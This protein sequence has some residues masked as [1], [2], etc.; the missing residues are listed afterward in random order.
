MTIEYRRVAK[1]RKKKIRITIGIAIAVLLALLAGAWLL[2]TVRKVEVVGNENYSAKEIENLV[3]SS[4]WDYNTI[5]LWYQNQYQRVSVPPFLDMVEIEI[6]SFHSIRIH[7]YEKAVVGYVEY[8]GKYVYF[9]KDGMVLETSNELKEGLPVVKGLV[10]D[11]MVLYEKLPVTDE[12]IFKTLVSL[13]QM[14]AKNKLVPS[15]IEFTS[16]GQIDMTF[17]EV[18]VHLGKDQYMD[19]KI[20]RLTGILPQLEGRSG[21]LSMEDVD[22]ATQ[23]ITFKKTKS[24]AQLEEEQ[25]QKEEEAQSE[26]DFSEEWSEEDSYEDWGEEDSEEWDDEDS[27]EDWNDEEDSEEWDDEDSWEDWS[28]EDLSEEDDSEE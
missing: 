9:D 23:R 14:L 24:K 6:V 19:N 17:G 8:L 25:R 26:E 27:Y 4:K 13:T 16:D 11:T 22:E 5:Y 15:C 10:F 12:S 18:L 21:I 7:A 28:G 1:A 3:L 2:C 20:A